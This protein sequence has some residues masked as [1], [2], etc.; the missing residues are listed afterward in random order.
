MKEEPQI[1][2]TSK[3]KI[4]AK[5]TLIALCIVFVVAG[6]AFEIVRFIAL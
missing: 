6:I 2:K 4:L 5:A 1:H 3:I